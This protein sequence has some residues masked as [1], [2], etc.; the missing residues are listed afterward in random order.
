MANLIHLS[1]FVLLFS[2]P[3]FAGELDTPKF[4]V[5]VTENCLEG[6]VACPDVTY[7][8]T[9]KTTGASLRLKG[10]TLVRLCADNVTPC[11]HAGYAFKH[12]SYEYL[13]GE[14]G[15]LVV[16]YRGKVIVDEMGSWD[17]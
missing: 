12:G 14:N 7:F 3:A 8:G 17:H 15:K 4:H 9:N 6:D 5:V 1:L 2:V 10:K 16:T 11:G 13:V